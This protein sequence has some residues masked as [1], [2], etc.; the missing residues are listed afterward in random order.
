MR[1]HLLGI[2]IQW[3]KMGVHCDQST[4]RDS[5]KGESEGNTEYQG[6]ATPLLTEGGWGVS[7]FSLDVKTLFNRSYDFG[8]VIVR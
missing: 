6:P 7:C 5:G 1:F 2:S 3:F 8:S 4:C